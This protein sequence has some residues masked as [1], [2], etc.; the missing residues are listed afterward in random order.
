MVIFV[1]VLVFGGMVFLHELGHF[2]AARAFKIAVDEFGFGFPPRLLRL[3]RAKGRLSVND[4]QIEIPSN[5]DLPVEAVSALNKP[6]NLTVDQ[7]RGRLILRT[8]EVVRPPEPESTDGMELPLEEQAAEQEDV[9]ATLKANGGLSTPFPKDAAVVQAQP[10]HRGAI[11]ISGRLTE[12][13][14]GTE[15]SL[16][17]LP[18]GGFV[19]PKGEGNPE[20]PGGLAAA[21]PWKRLGVLFAGP[22]MNLLTAVVVFALLVAQAGIPIDGPVTITSVKTGS[23]AFWAFF[24]SGDVLVSING[25]KTLQGGPARQEIYA[26]IGT[27]LD[28]VILRNGKEVHLTAIPSETRTREGMGALGISLQSTTRP[29]ALGEALT[30][31]TVETFGQAIGLLSIPVLLIQGQIQPED[32]R[33]VGMKG[34]YDMLAQAWTR[35]TETRQQPAPQN[36]ASAPEPT[37]WVLQMVAMLSVSLGVMNLLPIPALDG[38]RILFTLPEILFRRRIPHRLENLINSVAMMMLIALMLLVNLMDFINP[39][40]FKLP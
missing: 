19:L 18:L 20:I 8:F 17:W 36:A 21:N 12:L 15:F 32:A 3:W 23:P 2:M 11:A 16:N 13:E 26:N 35:D 1:F 9:L 22:L 30:I 10:V 7:V 29:A 5:F 28:V 38:G 39:A 4:Q 31:G 40:N 24:E 37:N 27:P 33:V 6:V 25:V 34:I 14:Q